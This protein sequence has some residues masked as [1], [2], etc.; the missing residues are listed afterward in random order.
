MRTA[1]GWVLLAL[2]APAFADDAVARVDELYAKRDEPKA[3]ED[4]DKLLT[5]ALKVKP[6][7]YGLLWRAARL[8]VWGA[9]TAAN[10][11][12]KKQEAKLAWDFGDRARKADPAKAE[13]HYWAAAG[14]GLFGEAHGIM[15]AISE[16]VAG[17]FC[18][19]VDKAIEIDPTIAHGGPWLARARYYYA[20]PWPMRDLKK[21]NELLGKVVEKYPNSLRAKLYLADNALKDADAKKAKEYLDQI[22][23]GG[24]G[25]DPPDGRRVKA[26][27]KKTLEK[28]E[29]ELK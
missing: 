29:E 18:E 5:D 22:F 4:A 13:G 16:G 17:K 24:D 6:D 8:H 3:V 26:D 15:K 1:I 10:D 14:V 7:D 20:V 2:S 11:S 23:A 12:R 28:V 21:S 27:A 25:D 9:N 19:R